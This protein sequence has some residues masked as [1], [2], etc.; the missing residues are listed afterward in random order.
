LP[1]VGRMDRLLAG[2]PGQIGPFRILGRLGE[3]GMGRVYLGESLGGRKVAVKVVH[4]HYASDPGFRSRFAR[5]VAAARQVGG[6]HTAG[7]VGADPDA[8]PPWMATAYIPGPS[9]AEAV[10]ASGPLDDGGVRRLGAALAEGLAAIHECGLIHRDLK[11]S[12]VILAEDG[13]RIIDFGIAK[14]VGATALTGSSAVIGTLRYMSP[15]QLQG[16]ELTP[17]S[18]VFALGTV[19][20]YAATGRDPFPASTMPAVITRILTGPPDLDPLTGDLRDIIENCL[21]KEPGR[22]P[23]PGDLLVHFSRPAPH[24]PTVTAAPAQVPAAEP[25]PALVPPPETRPDEAGPSTAGEPSRA[26]TVDISYGV[27]PGRADRSPGASSHEAQPARRRRA[28]RMIALSGAGLLVVAAIAAAAILTIFR[29]DALPC[30]STAPGHALLCTL[31]DPH[32][33]N[34]G[35]FDAAFSPDGKTLATADSNGS[36][37]LWNAASGHRIATLTDPRT[38]QVGVYGAVFSPDGKT[39]AT[40]DSNGSTYLWDVA[41]GHRIATLAG[42]QAGAFS[43]DGMTLAGSHN[44][45]TQLWDVASGHLIATFTDPDD[46]TRTVAFSPDGKTLA[47]GDGN[48]VT[49][50]WDVASG[51]LIAT[52]ADPSPGPNGVQSVAFSPDGKTLAAGDGDDSTY[53]WDVASGQL[54]A[55]LTNPR[56]VTKGF[57]DVT[58]SPDG[59]TLAIA[60][61][62]STS[63]YLWDVASGHRIAT[64]TDPGSG[65]FGV[66]VVA[67]SPDGKTLAAADSNGSTYLW[68]VG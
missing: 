28:R 48:G 57:Q 38:G 16:Q 41:S 54:I 39:L 4:P 7:V 15:E 25:A 53:L 42:F 44:G 18:D 43:P 59:K 22:R 1:G 23:T 49:Y 34:F 51:H 11:P 32:T 10:T 17:Q 30:A 12:N 26:D 14:A 64:L 46:V 21:A 9:L 63:T 33:G 65:P 24:D 45:I 58:F 5:E 31:T 60:S 2:D 36:T 29:G 61:G 3:G 37:Y 8:D 66:D 19:L 47:A 55:T 68:D 6:F 50:L 52:F 62:N 56:P 20:A 13:P 27:S 35:A 67:F 40:A